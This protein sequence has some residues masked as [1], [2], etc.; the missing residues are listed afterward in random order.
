MSIIVLCLIVTTVSADTDS[1]VG[2]INRKSCRD[3]ITEM[4]RLFGDLET[5][6]MIR[7]E[8][9][10]RKMERHNGKL[11]KI[12]E[13][14]SG[15]GHFLNGSVTEQNSMKEQ[16]INIAHIVGSLQQSMTTVQSDL[17]VVKSVT[18]GK[19]NITYNAFSRLCN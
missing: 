15:L 9:L 7:I 4:K 3:V 6:F 14:I 18:V 8:E 12:Q 10:E 16:I 19:Y 5:K 1:D 11:E 17:A 13:D 2:V